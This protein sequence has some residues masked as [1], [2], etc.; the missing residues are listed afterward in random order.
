MNVGNEWLVE[1]EGCSADSLRNIDAVRSACDEL[2]RDLSLN[3]IGE[4][5]WHRFPGEGGVTGLYLLSES[6]LACHTYPEIGVAT[7]NLY[8]CR[9]RP[10]WPWHERLVTLLGAGSVTVRVA[11]RG[12]GTAADGLRRTL[13]A[14]GRQ[15]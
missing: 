7:F 6:H 4:P 15:T 11:E 14:R 2:I 12:A 13:K 3:V 1:A 9:P 10:E 8:C 5:L